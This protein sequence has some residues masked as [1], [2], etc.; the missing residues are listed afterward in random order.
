MALNYIEQLLIL[1]STVTVC[2]SISAFQLYYDSKLYGISENVDDVLKILE[3][4]SI[5]QFKCFSDN[6]MKSNKEKCNLSVS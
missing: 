1:L 4:D 6:Q 5:P 3:N 2:V